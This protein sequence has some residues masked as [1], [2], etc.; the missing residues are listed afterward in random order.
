VRENLM[1]ARAEIATKTSSAGARRKKR[2]TC[3]LVWKS[4]GIG[5][6][7]SASLRA[8]GR[9]SG[10]DSRNAAATAA[11]PSVGCRK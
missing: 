10:T 5:Q 9:S 7:S 11:V 4:A 3:A 2:R 8:S 6:K 1:I